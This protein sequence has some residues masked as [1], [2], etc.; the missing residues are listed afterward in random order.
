MSPFFDFH[1]CK[2]LKQYVQLYTATHPVEREERYAVG[3][4][5]DGKKC[6]RTYA[7]PIKIG[8]G[9]RKPLPCHS[10]DQLQ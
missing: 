7:L 1:A 4:I 2:K 8:N 9:C 6:R 3:K 10:E 5:R